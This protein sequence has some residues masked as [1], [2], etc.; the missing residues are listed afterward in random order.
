MCSAARRNAASVRNLPPAAPPSPPD[1]RHWE[2]VNDFL[3]QLTTEKF[4]LF[5][6]VLTRV[7]GLTMTAP[8]YGGRDV[9]AVARVLLSFALALLITPMQWHVSVAPPGSMLGYLALAAGE[10]VIG[11][12]LGLG[13][14]ILFYGMQLAGELVAQV[15]GLML[16]DVYDP[17][18]ETTVPLFSRFFFLV[19]AAV[20]VCIGGHRMVL[21]GLL[22]TFAAI[23]P[24]ATGMPP[25]VADA[26]LL[27]LT[28]SFSLGLRAAAPT[29]AA[30]LAATLVMGL[31]GRTLPQLNVMVMGFG[32]NAMLTFLALGLTLGAA[33]WLL[34][35]YFPAGLETMLAGL[36]A[37][38]EGKDGA[39]WMP[40]P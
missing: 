19:A 5:T 9:P 33:V 15:G 1:H 22:D 30:L 36:G 4:L 28:E 18:S 40:E 35:D 27:L 6:L 20:F 3:A 10:L 2:L 12:S 38:P 21:A 11:I 14:M 26:F 29:V 17:S 34:H 31:I 24:G 39:A 8:I 25:D 32:I 37:V 16:A 23:G 7:T 13:I